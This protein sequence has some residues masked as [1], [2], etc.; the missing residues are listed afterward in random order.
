LDVASFYSEHGLWIVFGTVLVQQLG[1]PV[2]AFPLLILAGAQA[3]V[4]PVYGLWALMLSVVASSL[5]NYAWF[6]AG[7]RYGHRVLRAVCNVSLSPDSCARQAEN[8]F[9]RYGVGS[10]V[11]ARF[12]PGLGIVAP[13]LAGGF[14]VGAPAFLLYNG[15]GSALWAFAGITLGWAFHTEVEWLLDALATLGNRAVRWLAVVVVLYAAQRW[16]RRWQFR[17]ALRAARIGVDEL[18]AMIERGEAP[19]ILDARSHVMRE[20]DARSIPGSIA[21]DPDDLDHALAQTTRERE[22]VVYCAC[23]N[24]VTAAKIALQLRKRGV[25]RVRPLSGGIDAWDA[26]QKSGSAHV[27]GRHRDP[28]SGAFH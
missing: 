14:G 19:L 18:R 6:I 25:T 1:L 10:L 2:P 22:V 28:R 21:V 16:W 5:G 8:A 13:P 20:L 24:E 27:A 17:R 15:I 12:V 23:P 3:L 7:R 26:A 9:E 11:L 4:E